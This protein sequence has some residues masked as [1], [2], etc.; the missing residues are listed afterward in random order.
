M[1]LEGEVGGYVKEDDDMFEKTLDL[2]I[3][4]YGYTSSSRVRQ[5]ILLPIIIYIMTATCTCT[6]Y[7]Y[8]V[9]WHLFYSG[10]LRTDTL[11][12]IIYWQE[13]TLAFQT[14]CCFGFFGG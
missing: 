12:K 14:R 11:Y 10:L 8:Y 2:V 1:D 4:Q 6:M 9:H 5:V 7:L 13:F 3:D